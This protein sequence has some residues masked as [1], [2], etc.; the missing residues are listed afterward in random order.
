MESN[1]SL[2]NNVYNADFSVDALIDSIRLFEILKNKNIQIN[3]TFIRGN[4]IGS[5][6]TSSL[7]GNATNNLE[8]NNSFADAD[9]K[10]KYISINKTIDEHGKREIGTPKTIS[11]T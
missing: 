5:C 4:V 2:K 8:I 7:I 11:S 3:N 6:I 10:G 9:I 1:W